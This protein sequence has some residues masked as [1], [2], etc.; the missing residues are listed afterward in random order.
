[1]HHVAEIPE[2]EI[3]SRWGTLTVTRTV[4]QA[5]N[6]RH[7]V[8]GCCD[9]PGGAPP[10]LLRGD[11]DAAQQA[12][13]DEYAGRVDRYVRRIYQN[14]ALRLFGLWPP[15]AHARVVRA[16]GVRPLFGARI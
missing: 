5:G 9:G 1:M 12:V 15:F 14:P 11:V 13:L 10:Y 2:V 3:A 8:V 7:T 6:L 16:G 4:D